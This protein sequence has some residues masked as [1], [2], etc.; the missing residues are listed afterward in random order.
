MIDARFVDMPS[1]RRQQEVSYCHKLQN[2][3][4]VK[5]KVEDGNPQSRCWIFHKLC[6]SHYIMHGSLCSMRTLKFEVRQRT[7]IRSYCI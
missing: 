4:D 3:I 7:A 6:M 1:A 5:M 2:A